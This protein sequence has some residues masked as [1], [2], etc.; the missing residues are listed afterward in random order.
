VSSV[1]TEP[2]LVAP[3][4]PLWLA[5]GLGLLAAAAVGY[6][7]GDVL[8]PVLTLAAVAVAALKAVGFAIRG[9]L[10]IAGH[11]GAQRAGLVVEGALAVLLA[12]GGWATGVAPSVADGALI[13]MVVTSLAS[14]VPRAI[15]P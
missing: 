7:G 3:P 14:L 2:V 12:L 10:E 5:A 9:G 13:A 15:R 11:G 1:A 4:F 8:L 6:A